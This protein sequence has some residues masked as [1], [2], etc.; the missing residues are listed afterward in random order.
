MRTKLPYG[1]LTIAFA[2]TAC[3][4]GGG[5]ST[6]PSNAS[7]GS[8]TYNPS[9]STSSPTIA[10]QPA[11]AQ[12]ISMTN[13]LGAAVDSFSTF[14]GSS[15]H[16]A[17]ALRSS[18]LRRDA[19]TYGT[20]SNGVIV[21]V[22]DL[23]GDA[24][25][26]E[27]RVYYDAACTNLARDTVRL[28]QPGTNGVS[29]IVNS[30]AKQYASGLPQTPTSVRSDVTTYADAT[31]SG[32]GYPSL[33]PG[34]LRSSTGFVYIGSTKTLVLDYELVMEPQSNGVNQFCSDNA[35]YSIVETD[36]NDG[37]TYESYGWGSIVS[38]G[39]RTVNSDGSVSW[40]GTHAGVTYSGTAGSIG[41]TTGAANTSCPMTTPEFGVTGPTKLGSST[42]PVSAVYDD[43]VLEDLTIADASLA[44]GVTLNVSTNTALPPGNPDFIN[45]TLSNASG[46]FASFYVD[47]FGDGAL[48]ISVQGTVSQYAITA[49][50]VMK[51][52][53]SSSSPSGKQR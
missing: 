28:F 8:V 39:K 37:L 34:Y 42:L 44:G 48:T 53:A 7:G 10:D 43:G 2:L 15:E 31:I 22:P 26:T 16:A 38:S 5:G 47:A 50:H 1:L 35:G 3:G 13:S 49:W 36:T 33:T 21:N 17:F 4:G 30:T 18:A 9:G 23:N 52:P 14:E 6:I 24:N 12:V 19:T 11:R 45:G 41:I 46:P 27:T 51:N 40:S 32:N 25:S 29:E 20:C